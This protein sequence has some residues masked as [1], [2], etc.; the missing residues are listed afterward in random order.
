M[1]L[2]SKPLGHVWR[3][4]VSTK[5]TL[6]LQL[7]LGKPLR[8][9]DPNGPKRMAKLRIYWQKSNKLFDWSFAGLEGSSPIE[10]G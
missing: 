7:H 5:E 1:P 2:L 10:M 8:R 4:V 9:A 6:D 3:Q